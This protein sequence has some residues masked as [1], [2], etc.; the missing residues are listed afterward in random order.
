MDGKSAQ[1]GYGADRGSTI[2]DAGHETGFKIIESGGDRYESL[3]AALDAGLDEMAD[4][5]AQLI[6]DYLETGKLIAVD[7]KIKFPE[8][9][10]AGREE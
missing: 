6:M 8:G 1:K 2:E 9:H 3:E 7:G 10:D 5:M 4:A